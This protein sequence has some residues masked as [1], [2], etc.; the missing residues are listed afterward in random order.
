M[1]RIATLA[2]LLALT[3]SCGQDVVINVDS[4]PWG[5]AAGTAASGTFSYNEV[6]TESSC[7][8]AIMGYDV[9]SVTDTWSTTATL[10]QE[11]GS[12]E[13][14][15]APN[16]QRPVCQAGVACWFDGGIYWHGNFRIGGTYYWVGPS[17]DLS[18]INLVDGRF[19]EGVDAFEGWIQTRVQAS[20][21]T[22]C[23]IRF[24]FTGTRM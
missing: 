18:L 20:D 9:P 21:G 12:L 23:E 7:P 16:T 11:E 22:D 15:L 13:M 4:M 14:F 5:N 24:E 17:V 6:V 10:T 1:K 3:A 2:A 19:T 8:S